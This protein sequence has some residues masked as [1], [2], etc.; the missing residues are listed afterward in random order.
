MKHLIALGI[1]L[2]FVGSGCVGAPVVSTPDE[3]DTKAPVVV[4]ELGNAAEKAD[5]SNQ[6]LVSVSQD[7]FDR[8]ELVELN[9]S[10]NRLTG[11]IPAEIRKLSK[12]RTLDLS[13]NAM[14]GLPAEVGQLKDLRTLDLSNNQL[15][16][17]PMELGALTSLE[18][19]D[20]RGNP[21]SKIDLD[22]IRAKLSS[23]QILVD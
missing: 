4:E 12:L 1:S 15:T 2:L 19:L 23:T 7:I 8:T 9:L 18:T 22:Q 14:T 10:H 3:P 6:G 20:L 21:Y 11:A 16:G 5:L 13:D 17:L